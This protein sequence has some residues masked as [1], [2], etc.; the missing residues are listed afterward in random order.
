VG[1]VEATSLDGAVTGPFAFTGTGFPGALGTCGTSLAAGAS[2]TVE[3]QFVPGTTGGASGTIA[4]AFESGVGPAS[5]G[6]D[7]AGEGLAPASLEIA[8]TADLGGVLVGERSTRVL[9]LTNTGEVSAAL[10]VF[11]LDASFEWAAGTAD[12]SGDCDEASPLAPGEGCTIEVAFEPAAS[13][14]AT[15]SLSVPFT[16]AVGTRSASLSLSGHGLSPAVLALSDEASYDFGTI[17]VGA[18]ATHV[19]HVTNSGEW[20]AALG[21][22]SASAPFGFAGATYPGTGGSCG[23]TLEPG[24][25]CRVVL[26]FSPSAAGP[27]GG[28]LSIP[29][30]DGVQGR[31]ASL[32]LTGAAT[33]L[34]FLAVTDFPPHYY[35]GY[36]LPPD[37]PVHDYGAVGVGRSASHVFHV[38]NTGAGEATLLVDGG[39]SGPFGWKGGAYPGLGGTCADALAAGATCQVVVEFAPAGAGAVS[40]TFTVGYHDGMSD[41]AVTRSLSGSGT[42]LAS[43]VFYDFEPGLLF[44]ET[45]DFGPIG[46]GVGV[47]SEH[48]LWLVNAGAGA[49]TDVTAL[50]PPAGF[51]WKGGAFPGLGGTCGGALAAGAACRAVAVFQPQE[52]GQ[53][54]GELRVSYDDGSGATQIA[55]RAVRGTGVTTALVLV[56][57]EDGV[58][59]SFGVVGVGKARDRTLRIRN[60]GGAEAT[61]ISPRALAAPFSFAGTSWPG[62][63]GTCGATLASGA[64][65]LAVVRFAPTAAGAAGAQVALDYQDGAGA[66]VATR[67]LAGTGTDQ[68]LLAI[69]DH[70]EGFDRD[71]PRDAIE[72]GTSAAPVTR[73]LYVRNL[74]AQDATAVAFS[75]AAPFAVGSNACGATIAAGATCTIDVTFTPEG[76]GPRAATFRVDYDAGDAPATA[77]VALTGVATT[78][79]MVLATTCRDCGDGW[80]PEDHDFGTWGTRV[81]QT[82]YLRNVGAQSATLSSAVVVGAPVFDW[83]FGGAFPGVDPTVGTWPGDAP[84]CGATLAAGSAC[85]IAVAF[86]P[87]A[88]S[89]V[90]G[91]LLSIA[92]SDAGGEAG[93]LSFPLFGTSTVDPLVEI[94]DPN[95]GSWG[96]DEPPPIQFGSSGQDVTRQ[97]LVVNRGGGEATLGNAELPSGFS[98]AS[99]S[100]PGAQSP[101]GY[102][103]PC[104]ATLGAGEECFVSIRF[105]AGT[106]TGGT[107]TGAFTLA[108]GP[109]GHEA[110]RQLT[111]TAVE[112]ALVA[113][114]D[115][116]NQY[117]WPG[118]PPADFGTSGLPVTRTFYVTNSGR[119]PAMLTPAAFA[120][121]AFDWTPWAGGGFPGGDPALP[122]PEWSPWEGS[123][124]GATLAA[125]ATCRLSVTFTPP[126]GSS[127]SYADAVGVAYEDAGGPRGTASRAV[128][129]T[130]MDDPLLEIVD[131]PW[132]Q[133]WPQRPPY[134]FGVLGQPAM[135]VFIVRN[136][137]G[138]T[139]AIRGGTLPL[140]FAFPDAAGG[141]EGTFP[142]QASLDPSYP[143][144]CSDPLFEYLLEPGETCSVLVAFVPA[145]VVPPGT[146]QGPLLVAYD[147]GM[148]G[149][150][151]SAS[152]DLAGTATDRAIVSIVDSP[153]QT[154]SP[155]DV[156]PPL[157]FG[158][159]AQPVYRF[160]YVRNDGAA[161]ADLTAGP[162]GTAFTLLDPVASGLPAPMPWE[163]ADC[164]AAIVSGGVAPLA[165]GEACRVAVSFTA[166]LPGGSYSTTLVV[167]WADGLGPDGEARREL[168]GTSIDGPLLTIRD[169]DGG[170]WLPP[171]YDYG[172][173]G[174]EV[175]HWF[176]VRND[177]RAAATLTSFGVG[178]GWDVDE[179]DED[180]PP[181]NSPPAEPCRQG[182]T[183]GVGER[184]ALKVVFVPVPEGDPLPEPLPEGPASTTLEVRF[185]TGVVTRALVGSVTYDAFVFV[186]EWTDMPPCEETWCMPADFWTTVGS[187]DSRVL[188]VTNRG[189]ADALS[190]SDASAL[191]L[192]FGWADGAFPGRYFPEDTDPDVCAEGGTLA[193]GARCRLL[194]SFAPT[195]PGEWLDEVRVDYVAGLS[196]APAS[197]SRAL[198]GTAAPPP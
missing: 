86:S 173:A 30:D 90:H 119:Q 104:G 91:G 136:V 67:D 176:Y 191:D 192:P 146:V 87:P 21:T 25:S 186:S 89:G 82:V 155:G 99:G 95:G 114:A 4:L 6:A 133:A 184:C 129:G 71:E 7:L 145:A 112:S 148:G 11:S 1:D 154:S 142:G 22:V 45:W 24:H 160:L 78:R 40:G 38:T 17:A 75:T 177:G 193:P 103:P 57:P 35:S 94:V 44:G 73:T 166:P 55:A 16:D 10:G 56:E 42:D 76:D 28:A 161:A 69:S 68:A 181:G 159:H 113:V 125:G 8:G 61:G 141:Y 52:G 126:P 137:G 92:Y 128:V 188:W 147:D 138:A 101:G 140:G 63:G 123:F 64:E 65:C 3:L 58:V 108:W 197:A 167:G 53:A 194:V 131:S 196:G 163:P 168:A 158:A 43:L 88:S 98:W 48:D 164:P 127:E 33:D 31:A 50:A 143:P 198:R 19:V 96:G 106:L 18:T 174:T 132:D 36:G 12:A 100:W 54:S 151:I 115:S 110:S 171:A 172:L 23:A 134:D 175:E 14:D 121:V 34:A 41:Q 80:Y 5:A 179:E 109:G 130:A 27:A 9:T 120:S 85:R 183:L 29:Y 157:D 144:L 26:A 83:A 84:F 185:E 105:A 180:V 107:Y 152:R 51:G 70:L 153:T 189:G 15:G 37:G 102:P 169:D 149:A 39:L 66:A 139:A 60:V 59:V 81:E 72:L 77:S 122:P 162:L 2:C 187:T 111:G 20:P 178:Q 93:A 150:Q 74:G 170:G 190:L 13:G 165:P 118:Q 117:A 32:A 182:A 195:D 124:C 156:P 79:A 116:P 135:H 47:A 97:L 46:V 49:A 62:T